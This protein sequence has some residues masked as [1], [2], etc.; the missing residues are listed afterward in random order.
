MHARLWI[1]VT[2]TTAL[3]GG[4]GIGGAATS[5]EL[6]ASTSEEAALAQGFVNPPDSARPH[7]W[8]H[9]MNGMVS[10]EGITA[11]LEAMKRVGIGGAEIFNVHQDSP[12]GPAPFMSQP[13]RDMI[14][15]AVNEAHR[16]DL[17]L[18]IHN[19]AGWSSSGGPWVKP[20]YAMLN[21]VMSEINV[22]G[23]QRFDGKLPR[24]RMK[25]GF[26]K[27]IAVL[28]F[29]TPGGS[30]DQDTLRIDNLQAKAAY[31]RED[32]ITPSA[33]TSSPAEKVVAKTKIYDLTDKLG[34]DGKLTWDAPEG[35]WTIMRIGYT[36]TGAVNAPAPKA[37]RGL[38]VDKLSRMALDEFFAGMMQTVIDDN[39]DLIGKGLN[40][41]LVDSYEV[42]SQNW[43]PLLR[44]EFIQRRGYD[45]LPWMVTL[46]GRV[47]ENLA[48]SE[49]FLWD[50]RRTIAELFDENYFGYFTELC[51]RHGLT[52]SVEP[53]GNG[54]FNDLTAGSSFNIP[55]SEFWVSG[56]TLETAKI[57]SSI[58]HTNG[59]KVVGAESFTAAPQEGRWQMDPYAMKALGDSAFCLG[60][61]RFIFHT[62]AMQPWLDQ[63]P[64]MTMGP[65]GTRFGRTNTWWEQS[66]A[67]MKYIA[68]CQY[69][70]QQGQFVGDVCYYVGED[71]PVSMRVGNPPLPAG[72]DYDGLSVELLLNKLS[73]RDGRLVL[74]DGMSYRVLVLPPTDVMTPRVA[75]K[76]KELVAGGATVIGPKPTR[77]PSLTDY[78]TC[79]R[80]VR[81]IADEVWGECDGKTVTEHAY[82]SGRIICGQ[83]LE[84]VL[85]KMK[86]PADFTYSAGP[87]VQ[88][89][90]IHR[91]IGDADVYFVSNQTAL[92]QV[93]TCSFRVAGRRPQLWHPDSGVIA[94]AAVYT[95]ADGR[96]RV[97][98]TLDPSG[99]VFVFFPGSAESADH[100]VAVNHGDKS[101]LDL[102]PADNPI[103]LAVIKATYGV[104]ND[105]AKCVDVTRHI[106]Q[107]LQQGIT[108]FAA[109]NNLAGDPAFGIVKQMRVEYT[110]NGKPQSITVREGQT[111]TFPEMLQVT[112]PAAE[113]FVD[114]NGALKLLAWEGGDYE[115][116]TA[117]GKSIAMQVPAPAKPIRLDG[118]WEVSFPPHLGTPDHITMPKL[119][120]WTEADVEGVKYFSGTATYKQTFDVPASLLGPGKRL[121]LDLGK[122]KNLAQVTINGKDLGI[123]WKPPFS[124]DA[125]DALKTGANQIVIRI[126]NLWP[127]RLIGDQQYPDDCQWRGD[128]LA[129]WPD[130]LSKHE[131]RP[132]SRRIT[133]TT[134]KQWDKGDPLLESGLI[135]PVVLRQAV[136]VDIPQ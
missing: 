17:Q 40:D 107:M 57:A 55:M 36:P 47:V 97:P 124:L 53:Y 31:K 4:L 8:W 75:E 110:V 132:S 86:I 99:S 66:T 28:A 106:D 93:I 10:K 46:S 70:L 94:P 39:R 9:W 78:P 125:T 21:V 100:L 79:D 62:Y 82:G 91:V 61:N 81:Q 135:G 15:H 63:V 111:M 72:Y 51:H 74:P 87:A 2:M 12:E 85:D 20:E 59:Q 119:I 120:S 77:S 71:S 35:N 98:I 118:A 117:S 114:R 43:T 123:L 64:G 126:T 26:Y 133:F 60:V 52:S 38:E 113:P 23:G 103:K 30:A 5:A 108:N 105:P 54:L 13:W 83:S 3:W 45:P 68:R 48:Q 122:V 128:H 41:A 37:G 127:N 89:A 19:C 95:V 33:D 102:L 90:Y 22:M 67:W 11:D 1:A 76:I 34:E 65:W 6:P 115:A 32:N 42:G 88:L 96:T 16:L 49:R 7:T 134:R 14:R 129:A 24:P 84:Q 104:L 80:K 27:D 56:G 116:T 50:Y 44:T 136:I 73:V 121:Y 18:C 25:Q 92:T 131:P 112:R 29:P 130:W 58:A 101:A 69:L 109:G